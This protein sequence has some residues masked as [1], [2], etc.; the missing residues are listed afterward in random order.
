MGCRRS[1]NFLSWEVVGVQGQ[2]Q[3]GAT[4]TGKGALE[5]QTDGQVLEHKADCAWV[6]SGISGCQLG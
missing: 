6:N 2:G 1:K 5:V 3:G 4:F